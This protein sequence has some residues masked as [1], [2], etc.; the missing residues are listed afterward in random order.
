MHLT[1]KQEW[2]EGHYMGQSWVLKHSINDTTKD[3]AK[4]LN[5]A[6]YTIQA[7][8]RIIFIIQPKKTIE[9]YI[10]ISWWQPATTFYWRHLPILI[11][12][13]HL[14]NGIQ[15]ATQKIESRIYFGMVIAGGAWDAR[16]SWWVHINIKQNYHVEIIHQISC[17]LESN[18]PDLG[19]C[20]SQQSAMKKIETTDCETLLLW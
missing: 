11:L 4:E 12:P 5:N 9:N 20:C 1:V 19:I 3:K 7:R 8:N 16:S 10:I 6:A 18:A 14:L 2:V 17:S 15:A 13:K